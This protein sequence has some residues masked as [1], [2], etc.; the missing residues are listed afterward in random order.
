MMSYSLQ[1]GDWMGSRGRRKQ[2]VSI[3]Y[4]LKYI[5]TFFKYISTFFIYKYGD[6]G[7]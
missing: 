5:N 7:D 4:S 1:G 6:G 2:Y 3:V